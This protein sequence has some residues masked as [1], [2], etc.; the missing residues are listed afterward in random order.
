MRQKKT[1]N[2]SS[3]DVPAFSQT[4]IK[5]Q[6]KVY[7]PDT[8]SQRIVE[9]FSYFKD[10][11]RRVCD[12][13]AGQGNF[14]RI[15]FIE[16]LKITKDPNK[17][18]AGIWGFEIDLP[19]V[20]KT[21]D[22]FI[23]QGVKKSTVEQQIICGNS[24]ELYTNFR[25]TFDDIIGNPPY[26]RNFKDYPNTIVLRD[27]L[28]DA[29]F[30]IGLE[31]LRNGNEHHL[32]YITQDSF[33]TN[34]NS[35]LREYLLQFNL[36]TIEHNYEFSRIFRKHD[37]AVDI[38]LIEMSKGHQQPQVN[39]SRHINFQLPSN[40]FGKEK[41]L[42]YPQ[43][44]QQLVNKLMNMGESLTK[45]YQIKKG[46]T[47]NGCSGVYSS[48]GNKTFSKTQNSTFT[49]PV[50]AEPNTDYFFVTNYDPVVFGKPTDKRDDAIF[51]PFIILPYFT[52][53]FRFC[54]V[55]QD[56]LTTPLL[57]TITG[58]NLESILP[59]LNSSVTD[60]II[61]YHTKSRDTGY[62]F[63]NSTF[64]NIRLPVLTKQL[65]NELNALVQLVRQ[66]NISLDECDHWVITKIFNLTPKEIILINECKKFWFK[67]NVKTLMAQPDFISSLTAISI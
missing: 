17:A 61:R 24:L 42:I 54:I 6:G 51:S 58:D 44:V 37:I 18:F 50:L 38:G 15:I 47:A 41:W 23:Q 53:K 14:L 35:S 28:A 52:S 46:K 2:T 65:T 64:D 34:E 19:A 31:M 60:F 62:E 43:K 45:H 9:R 67:K 36:K 1:V 8:I 59:I 11:N 63:K 56:M 49:V 27:N 29:F 39:V 5:Q 25:N 7:T 48:Y 21:K 4:E 20:N 13:S 40:C 12:P 10:P 57:Y 66:S 30:Q 22:F 3:V 32:V 16:R 55:E 33:I 26:V